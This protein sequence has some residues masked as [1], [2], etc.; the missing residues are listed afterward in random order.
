MLFRERLKVAMEQL[1]INQAQLAGMTGIEKLL[2]SQYLS[3]KNVPTKE[4][5]RNMAMSLGLAEDYFEQV[6]PVLSFL[7]YGGVP[8]LRTKDAG[9]LMR[10]SHTTIE[11]GLKQGLFNWGYAIKRTSG[12]YKYFI[13]A[14]SFTEI[15]GIEVPLEMMVLDSCNPPGIQGG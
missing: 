2:I 12:R 3:G 9:K 1:G 4:R 14:R 6:D 10:I 15:E 7:K 11:D 8:E 13:N 5:Q